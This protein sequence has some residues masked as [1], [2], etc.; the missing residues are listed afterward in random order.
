MMIRTLASMTLGV[1]ILFAAPPAYAEPI[2]AANRAV[3]DPACQTSQIDGLISGGKK[4]D[5]FLA[6]LSCKN[7]RFIVALLHTATPRNI[8][9]AAPEFTLVAKKEVLA[10][11]GETVD[12]AAGVCNKKNVPIMETHA[13]LAK[14]G[15]HD[16]VSSKNG[17]L[18][19]IAAS[20][21]KKSLIS[22]P[23]NQ[24]TCYADKP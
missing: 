19:I 2:A 22:L 8:M 18:R 24:I 4:Q 12:L 15:E 11:K 3:G 10:G 14:W 21:D 7:S 5:K 23:I 20:P 9:D 16:E 17:L 1:V 6:L 13:M